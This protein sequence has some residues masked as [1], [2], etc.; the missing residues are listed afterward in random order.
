MGQWV[1]SSLFKD[2]ALSAGLWL[3]YDPWHP[4]VAKS[5]NKQTKNEKFWPQVQPIFSLFFPQWPKNKFETEEL[6]GRSQAVGIPPEEE[7]FPGLSGWDG[8]VKFQGGECP[9]FG[10]VNTGQKWGRTLPWKETFIGLVMANYYKVICALFFSINHQSLMKVLLK[11][12]DWSHLCW[13]KWE[14]GQ[15]CFSGETVEWVAGRRDFFHK[16]CGLTVMY[17]EVGEGWMRVSRGGRWEAEHSPVSGLPLGESSS[18]D[19][20]AII[21]SPLLFWSLT[22]QFYCTKLFRLTYILSLNPVR[23][24]KAN[25]RTQMKGN[26][27]F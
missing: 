7:T 22:C 19:Y 27:N 17:P 24:K 20:E 18:W 13:G 16:H 8:A 4:T 26:K 12:G 2:S 9:C 6:G 23:V 11:F 10:L 14:K 5:T 25:I 1:G 21:M 3:G 15:S